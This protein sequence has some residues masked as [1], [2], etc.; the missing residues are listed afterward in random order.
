[1][2]STPSQVPGELI[3]GDTWEWTRTLADYP[4][5]E[6]TS[7]WHFENATFG[8]SVEGTASDDTHIAS[9][10]ATTIDGLLPGSYRWWLS[11]TRIADSVRRTVEK[12]WSTVVADP[13][14]VG[15]V[16][17]R[18]TARIALEMIE[19]YL[20]DPTNLT[21]A[22]YQVGG[23]S[24]SRWSRADLLAERDKWKMEVAAEL[25]GSRH[26]YARLNRV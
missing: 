1:M 10:D 14:A 12:G 6:W 8:F 11:L 17:Y 16:D 4:A 21:A 13:A 26:L 23:R 22:S 18:S 2:P 25:G 20:T 9:I 15:N 19:A 24:L 7:E 3:G 5:S